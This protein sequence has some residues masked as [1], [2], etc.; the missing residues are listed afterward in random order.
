[1]KRKPGADRAFKKVTSKPS[2]AEL[3][4]EQLSKSEFTKAQQL[5][6]Q[7]N[8]EIE[9]C[10]GDGEFFNCVHQR[11]LKVLEACDLSKR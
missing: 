10:I 5:A 8:K 11:S 6:D 3:R 2:I 4:G 9:T 7:T 1:M